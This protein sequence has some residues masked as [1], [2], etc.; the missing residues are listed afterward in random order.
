M[1]FV[2]S[3]AI[4]TYVDTDCFFYICVEAVVFVFLSS[5]S[6]SLCVLCEIF[7]LSNADTALFST[8]IIFQMLYNPILLYLCSALAFVFGSFW[9]VKNRV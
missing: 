2:D 7:K 8:N 1:W 3:V 4:D 9:F 6:L 5:L